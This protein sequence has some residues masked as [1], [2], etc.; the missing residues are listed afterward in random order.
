MPYSGRRRGRSGR[1]SSVEV[2]PERKESL[3][4][5]EDNTR[6]RPQFEL[7]DER[8]RGE[9][10]IK[11]CQSGYMGEKKGK[12]GSPSKEVR[13]DNICCRKAFFDPKDGPEKRPLFCPFCGKSCFHEPL[14]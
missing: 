2:T 3:A 5:E 4:S 9:A 8:L 11:A 14:K 10:F 12:A 6:F 1:A 13:C 7:W